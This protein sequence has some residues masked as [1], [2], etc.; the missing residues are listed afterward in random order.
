MK[1]TM[2]TAIK[3]TIRSDGWSRDPDG[4]IH[5]TDLEAFLLFGALASGDS[6]PVA[7]ALNLVFEPHMSF[8]AWVLKN[9]SNIPALQE[10]V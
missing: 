4:S 1:P 7:Y 5:M 9:G 10:A 8:E 3:S 6:S 2:L